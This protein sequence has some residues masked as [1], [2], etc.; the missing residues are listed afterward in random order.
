MVRNERPISELVKVDLIRDL[1]MKITTI[2]RNDND[3][4]LN[5]FS[6]TI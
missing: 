1:T 2:K 3:T 6:E 4:S 5:N